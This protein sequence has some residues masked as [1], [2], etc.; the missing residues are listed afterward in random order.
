MRVLLL[1][2]PVIL[3]KMLRMHLIEGKWRKY[4][5]EP[6]MGDSWGR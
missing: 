5:E 6:E 1:D 2:Q 4:S 3:A